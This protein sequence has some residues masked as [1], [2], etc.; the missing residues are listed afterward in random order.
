[1]KCRCG[2]VVSLSFSLTLVITYYSSQYAT[3]TPKMLRVNSIETIQDQQQPMKQQREKN[4][5]PKAPRDVCDAVSVAQ[6]G[7]MALRMP[8]PIPL[9]TRAQ[10]IHSG[11]I[12]EHCKMAPTVAH[13]QATPIV[14]RRPYLS[15][16]Q[17]PH[18]APTSVPGK[19]ITSL[20]FHV[21]SFPGRTY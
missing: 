5:T 14:L 2:S 9:K 3:T 19:L 6:T 17:P 11:F 1:M 20:A 12:A 13:M 21:C 7:V 4:D 10:N 18:K 8:V 15:P 16:I